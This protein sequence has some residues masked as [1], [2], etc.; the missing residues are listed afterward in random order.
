M[1]EWAIEA[2][3]RR[4]AELAEAEQRLNQAEKA[5]DNDPANDWIPDYPP[6]QGDELTDANQ[7]GE[8]HPQDEQRD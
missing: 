6:Q 2:T 3:A 7:D 8:E 4:A 5:N 1:L